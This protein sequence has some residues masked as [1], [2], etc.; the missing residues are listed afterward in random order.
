ML[1]LIT[2]P[3]IL[4]FNLCVVLPIRLVFSL[5]TTVVLMR[6]LYKI[7]KTKNL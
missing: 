6:D 7:E 4:A 5:F 3:F 1:S 2:I